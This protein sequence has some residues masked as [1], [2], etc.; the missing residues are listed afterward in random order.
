[1]PAPVAT[2]AQPLAA[3][4]FAVVEELHRS[5]GGA[6]FLGRHRPTGLKVVLKE[7][8]VSELGHGH[9]LE[10]EVAMYERVPRHTNLIAFLGSYRRGSRSRA[11]D[12]GRHLL[13]SSGACTRPIA[14]PLIAPCQRS[15]AAPCGAPRLEV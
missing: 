13:R 12:A 11:G 14:S 9:E 6:V 15:R 10:N 8:R 3:E 1:M 7:R 5:S 4:D 2:L